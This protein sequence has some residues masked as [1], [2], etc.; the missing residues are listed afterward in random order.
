M[1]SFIEGFGYCSFKGACLKSFNEGN[2]SIICKH[3]HFCFLSRFLLNS[4]FYYEIKIV[5]ISEMISFEDFLLRPSKVVDPFNR[6]VAKIDPFLTLVE[7]CQV[8]GPKPLAVVSQRP[9]DKSKYLYTI[10][11]NKC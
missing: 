10:F 1:S 7:F 6:F 5:L 3:F 11:S 4:S 2:S 8:I 9:D